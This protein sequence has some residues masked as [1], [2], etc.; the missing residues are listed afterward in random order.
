MPKV[1]F[2]WIIHYACNYRCP[3]CFY[4]EGAGWEIL[5]ERNVYLSTDEWLKHW[6]RIYEK[7]GR[8][9]IAIT[10]GEPFTYPNFIK[11][12]SRLA[13]LH[14]PLNISTNSSGDFAAFV[15]WVSP[16]RVSLSLSFHPQYDKLDIFLKRIEFLRKWKFEGCINFVAYPPYLKNIEYYIDKFSSIGERLKIIPFR[17][18]YKEIAYPAG[19]TEAE[20]SLIGLEQEWFVKIRKK[21]TLCY[22]GRESGLLLPDGQVSRCG[23]LW[24]NC[25]IGNFFDFDFELLHQAQTCPVEM[26]PCNE[27]ILWGEQAYTNK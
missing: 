12:I 4:Y 13:D 8:C 26:C 25:I 6:Q 15:K 10:G 11:L 9:Y 5:K 17:G 14:Y 1:R 19:Y 24:Y 16:E 2:S 23:Q 7:Y 18:I 20:R 3:Y 27:D 21:A 22:A